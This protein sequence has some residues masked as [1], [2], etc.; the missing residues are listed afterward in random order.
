VVQCRHEDASMVVS[1][2]NRASGSSSL[3]IGASESPIPWY[4]IVCGHDL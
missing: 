2:Q 1:D 3:K 4:Y